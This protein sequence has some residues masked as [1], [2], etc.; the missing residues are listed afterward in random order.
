MLVESGFDIGAHSATHPDLRQCGDGQ[1]ESEVLGA[2]RLLEERLH[3]DIV[4]FSYPHGLHDRRVRR[5]VKRAGYR[6]GCT[7]RYGVNRT[8]GTPFCVSR[9]EVAGSDSLRDFR[10][11][12]QGKYDWLGYWQN[13]ARS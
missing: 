7:S 5:A 9:T 12:L 6:L 1:L 11:K 3:R 2:K 8:P 13:I 10:W 4:S